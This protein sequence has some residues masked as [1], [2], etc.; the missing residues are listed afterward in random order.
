MRNEKSSIGKDPADRLDRAERAEARARHDAQRRHR[1]LRD[2]LQAPAAVEV[3]KARDAHAALGRFP[4][5][6]G[7]LRHGRHELVPREH[8]V[9]D[10]HV[11]A[12]DDVL[13]VLQPV[14][15][16]DRRAA[17]AEARVVGLERLALAELLEHVDA[18]QEG[19]PLR[20][21]EVREDQAVALLERIP[22]LA[23][24]APQLAAP[25]SHGWSRQRP[26]TANFQ[27]W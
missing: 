22:G 1:R 8:A 19:L 20:R 21:A 9:Q 23:D 12:V 10:R 15:R 26:S 25:G 5:A 14:A 17:A 11:Q 13:P 24:V 2:A 27:P 16:D 3:A 4:M 6:L 7:H 18:R